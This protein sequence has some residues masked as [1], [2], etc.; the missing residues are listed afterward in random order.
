MPTNFLYSDFQISV[1]HPERSGALFDFM[2][3]FAAFLSGIMRKRT[4]TRNAES[5]VS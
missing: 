1:W 3:N 5:E 2:Q 4:P